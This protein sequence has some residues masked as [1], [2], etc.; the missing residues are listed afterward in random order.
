MPRPRFRRQPEEEPSCDE[1][2]GAPPPRPSASPYARVDSSP[3]REESPEPDPPESYEPTG[4]DEFHPDR[5]CAFAE[6]EITCR[7]EELLRLHQDNTLDA[8]FRRMVRAA[9]LKWHP[10]KHPDDPQMA[11]LRFRRVQ[12]AAAALVRLQFTLHAWLTPVPRD[13]RRTVE[14]F[15]RRLRDLGWNN[16][17]ECQEIGRSVMWEAALD[18]D[19]DVEAD[20]PGAEDFLLPPGLALARSHLRRAINSR[21]NAS[22]RIP[23]RPVRREEASES[24]TRLEMTEPSRENYVNFNPVGAGVRAQQTEEELAAPLAEKN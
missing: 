4:P 24:L 22:G 11:S 19:D 5:N 16:E 6:L 10:D 8:Y 1:T 18:M 17:S 14:N 9:Q 3:I 2:T 15:A 7:T 21:V 23:L 12:G 13:P 20:D